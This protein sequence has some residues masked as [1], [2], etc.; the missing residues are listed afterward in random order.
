[1]VDLQWLPPDLE[2]RYEH[3]RNSLQCA[4][5]SG[6]I[7]SSKRDLLEQE[8]LAIGLSVE[9]AQCVEEDY[10]KVNL[11]RLFEHLQERLT[12]AEGGIEAVGAWQFDTKTQ[13]EELQTRLTT[14]EQIIEGLQ[15]HYTAAETN[16]NI[17]Q[18]R[19]TDLEKTINQSQQQCSHA[20]EQVGKLQTRLVSAEGLIQ[21]LE[22]KLTDVIAHNSQH[23]QELQVSFTQIKTQISELEKWVGRELKN[24]EARLKP[25]G[26][27][28]EFNR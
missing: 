9:D 18:I 1:M 6:D 2:R 12:K 21:S 15:T 14:C 11:V 17:L 20:E 24:L 28:E 26:P 7:D 22:T 16:T 27:F 8:R 3:Y 25:L 19:L 23:I 4:Y 10:L 13:L 5:T